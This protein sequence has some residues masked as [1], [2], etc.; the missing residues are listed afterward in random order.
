[1]P[2]HVIANQG[3]TA[4]E[5]ATL[6]AT[7]VGG[8]TADITFNGFG[9]AQPSGQTVNNFTFSAPTV[10]DTYNGNSG[11]DGFYLQAN[12][13]QVSIAAASALSPS[14]SQQTL[15]ITPSTGSTA[16]LQFYYDT[17]LTTP[18]S[19]SAAVTIGSGFTATQVSGIYVLSGTPSYNVVT[20]ASNMSH[21]FY[22]TPLITYNA[23]PSGT[24]T[25]STTSRIT[26][27]LSGGAF[28]STIEFTNATVAGTAGSTFLISVG[29]SSLV[30]SNTSSSTTINPSQIAAIY[31][32][33]SVTLVGGEPGAKPTLTTSSPG[34]R[35]MRISSS[36]GLDLPTT[37]TRYN[38]S[39]D[40]TGTAE[41]QVVNGVVCAKGVTNSYLDYTNY[42]YA[43]ATKNSLNYSGISTAG[44]RYATFAWQ[45]PQLNSGVN[46]MTFT[47]TGFTG[48]INN[49]T[50]RQSDGVYITDN[51]GSTNKIQIYYMFVDANNTD[52]FNSGNPQY[53]TS[54]WVDANVQASGT[55]AI[56]SSNFNSAAGTIFNAA[57]GATLIGTTLTLSPVFPGISQNPTTPN[58]TTVSLVLRVGL[59]MASSAAFDRVTAY[60]T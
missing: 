57:A 42:Y 9:G 36:A 12:G 23:L 7:L 54:N 51:T 4:S 55:G 18:P 19:V 59:P 35:G 38:Q 37:L 11:R 16:L 17:P 6:T 46:T 47:F 15:Q 1:M 34:G 25:E 5:L 53:L 33:L 20:T 56:T 13:N 31:D 52:K 14:Q 41:L 58:T 40:I 10:V 43:T 22:R 60:Y 27:G 32:P 48:I 45:F 28:M 21:Y 39:T 26:S 49:A 8:A 29:L 30:A 2:I 44:Y 3:S 24:A 50:P